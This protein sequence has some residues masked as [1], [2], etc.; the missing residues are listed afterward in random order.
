[1]GSDNA[2]AGGDVLHVTE[3]FFHPNY[4]PQT[5]EFNFAVLKLHKN[6]SLGRSNMNVDLIPF[7][8]EQLVPVDKKITFLG[9]G[10]VLVRQIMIKRIVKT[11]KI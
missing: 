7:S 2:T 1:V 3:I 9:W 5:L 4:K 6:M 8:R 10:S 11:S